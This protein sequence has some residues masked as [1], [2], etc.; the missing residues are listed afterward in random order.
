MTFARVPDVDPL[1]DDPVLGIVSAATLNT[2]RQRWP[3]VVDGRGGSYAPS[4]AISFGAGSLD[5]A[6]DSALVVGDDGSYFSGTAANLQ[7]TAR[8]VER[9]CSLTLVPKSVTNFSQVGANVWEQQ[10]AAGDELL[11][12]HGCRIPH[13]AELT[14]LVARWKGSNSP[15][16]AGLPTLPTVSLVRIDSEG[17]ATAVA[18]ATDASASVAAYEA[19]HDLTWNT[20]GVTIDKSQFRYILSVSGEDNPNFR[21][22]ALLGSVKLSFSVTAYT[23]F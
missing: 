16:H 4:T 3:N 5:A 21:A 7:L 15:T 12:H 18:T 9:H 6:Y 20:G 13:G 10:S 14:E 23:E 22:N 8:T 19:W 2:W 17:I 11:L 1:D